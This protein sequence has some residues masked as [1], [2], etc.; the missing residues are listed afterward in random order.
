MTQVPNSRDSDS[1]LL[2]PLYL[3]VVC[4]VFTHAYHSEGPRGFKG[5]A[6]AIKRLC[7]PWVDRKLKKKKKKRER[8]NV[9][10]C[11]NVKINGH[12]AQMPRHGKQ[13]EG[14]AVFYFLTLADITNRSH[15]SSPLSQVAAS[16]PFLSGAPGRPQPPHWS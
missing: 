8:F 3:T 5:K 9:N 15:N 6:P 1:I 13:T 12:L 4:R 11:E 2:V 7:L 14:P 10:A 16:W